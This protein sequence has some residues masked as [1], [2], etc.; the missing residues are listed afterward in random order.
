MAQ[1]LQI[2]G[3][4]CICGQRLSNPYFRR[5]LRDGLSGQY[6]SLIVCDLKSIPYYAICDPW[7][8][9]Q[10]EA[11]LPTSSSIYHYTVYVPSRE[12]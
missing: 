8:P 10:P 2:L 5:P 9:Y 4:V 3:M 12:W 7:V 1:P 11:V 6:L